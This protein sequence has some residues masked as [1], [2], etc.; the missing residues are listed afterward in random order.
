MSSEHTPRLNVLLFGRIEL[1]G[2]NGPVGLTSRKLAALLAYLASTHPTPH[3]REK[4]MTLLWGTHFEAQARQNFRQALSGLRQILGKEVIVSRGDTVSLD[5]ESI[6]CDVPRFEMLVRQGDPGALSEA[7]DLYKDR[8]LSDFKLAE[9][10]WAEWLTREQQRLEDMALRAAMTL[11]EDAL[12]HGHWDRAILLAKRAIAI[13]ELREDAH[14]LLMR[15]ASLAGRKAEALQQYAALGALL[16]RELDVEPDVTTRQLAADIRAKADNVAPA[17]RAVP[18]ATE[19]RIRIQA[20]WG[21]QVPRAALA[22]QDAAAG[23]AEG[24]IGALQIAGAQLVDQFHARIASRADRTLLLEFPDPRS[25]V[26]AAHAVRP[27]RLRMSAHTAKSWDSAKDV[28]ARL[29][30]LA[31]PGHLVV[32][33]EVCDALTDGLDAHIEDLGENAI[34]GAG[35]PVRSYRVGP[36]GMAAPI[37]RRAADLRI[38]PAIAVIPFSVAGSESEQ[39]IIGQLLAH[40]IIA[41]LCQAKDFTVISRMSTR[42]FCGR[43][44]SLPDIG[45]WLAADYALWGNCEILG[46][47]ISVQIELANTSSQAVTWAGRLT[48]PIS[49]AQDGYADIVTEIIAETNAAVLAHELQRAHTQP[50]ETLENYSLL[51]TAI[52]LIHRTSPSGFARARKV[53]E[54]LGERLPHHPLPQAWMARWHVMKVSQGWAEDVDAEGQLALDCAKQATDSDP[55]CSIAIA[56]D[57]WVHTHLLKRFD[58]AAERFELAVEVNAHDSM[59]WL[60]KGAMHSFLGQ[61]EEAVEAAERAMRL[62]PLDPR[63]SYY[64][65]LAASA[66]C[67]ANSFERAIELGRRSLRVN[68][69]HAS[70]LRSLTCSLALSGR[71]D[72]AR[73]VAAELMKLE[74]KLTV[75]SY[76]S[77]HPAASFWTGKAWADALRAAGVPD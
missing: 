42:A 30:L 45:A 55:N 6:S 60:F 20:D 13:D 73:Q 5:S 35:Q 38:Q 68:R 75:R 29:L 52:N 67:A 27:H 57:G 63:R 33:D 62:S 22:L 77:R 46:D 11:G 64:D 24:Q 17:S 21:Q 71:V 66:Y 70:T 40:E 50:L 76:L 58:I 59:A 9:E 19:D 53:L 25:A 48:A 61:G 39:A 54:L 26:H 23:N 15:A 4:L 36:P 43:S 69:L 74:P 32:S 34:G 31:G 2:P 41:R 16:K 28:A 51:M 1:S 10:G 37:E 12:A 56:M 18:A 72:E 44:A 14:R 47:R 8:F 3:S 7:L 65:C 49:G